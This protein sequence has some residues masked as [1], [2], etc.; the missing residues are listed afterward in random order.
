MSRDQLA[1]TNNDT[2]SALSDDDLDGVVGGGSQPLS[3]ALDGIKFCEHG[4]TAPHS[5]AGGTCT[6]PLT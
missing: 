3:S 6:G 2:E 5:I 1:S 4:K